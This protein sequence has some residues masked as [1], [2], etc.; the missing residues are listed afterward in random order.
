[1]KLVS[2]D[3]SEIGV[4]SVG[5]FA[6]GIL[7]FGQ[8]A[9]GFIAIGQIA[10][11]VI[12]IGQ[13]SFSVLGAG[14][15][16]GGIAWFAG[17][18]GVGGR[19][20]CLRLI[21]G[22]DLPREPPPLVPLDAAMRGEVRGFVRAEVVDGPSGAKL[23]A[24]GHVLPV[25]MSPALLRALTDAR[26]AG[27]V[28]EIFAHLGRIGNVVVCDRLMEIPAARPSTFGMPFQIVRFLLLVALATGWWYTFT[29]VE[30]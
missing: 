15:A 25:K 16:G 19:G 30:G 11:G 6:H 20:V 24:Q 26:R 23:A 10:V 21:P 5:Q 13:V 17:M 14:Q 3:P 4:V 9:R 18:L 12:A 27:Q 29:R 7:A 2:T 28:R 22:L 1:M 8:F